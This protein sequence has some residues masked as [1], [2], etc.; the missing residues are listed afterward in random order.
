MTKKGREFVDS[1]ISKKKHHLEGTI[2]MLNKDVVFR[3][4]V[5]GKQGDLVKIISVNPPALTFEN[6]NGQKFP[7]NIKD[8]Y[9]ANSGI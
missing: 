5:Y 3:G 4:K 8:I 6:S 2:Q 9:N 1:Y 7:C